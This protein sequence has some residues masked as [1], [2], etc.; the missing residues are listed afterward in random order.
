MAKKGKPKNPGAG[1]K[2]TAKQFG[3]TKGGTIK[4]SG[5]RGKAAAWFARR[6]KSK[7]AKTAVQL[8][9]NKKKNKTKVKV[10][11]PV[12]VAVKR[13]GAMAAAGAGA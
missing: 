1:T 5:Y 11:Q 9:P 4:K 3:A 7:L 2:A 8:A 6:K 10:K 12:A 13:R